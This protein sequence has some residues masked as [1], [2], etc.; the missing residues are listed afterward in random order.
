MS[1]QSLGPRWIRRLRRV[2]GLDV[3]RGWSHGGYDLAFATADHQHG[4]F[5]IKAYR[6]VTSGQAWGIEEPDQVVHYSSCPAPT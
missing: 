2:T 5:D 4:W 6:G 1:A 3:V